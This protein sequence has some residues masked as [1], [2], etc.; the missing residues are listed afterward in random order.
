MSII[1]KNWRPWE[2]NKISIIEQILV[3][4]HPSLYNKKEKINLEEACTKL[5]ITKQ[6]FYNW[7]KANPELRNRWD[8]AIEIR[9]ESIKLVARE[10]VF[11][12]ITWNTKLRPKEKIEL[13]KWVLE[14][15]D[16]DFNPKQVIESKSM[17]LNF[18]VSIDEMENQLKNLFINQN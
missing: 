18:D 15:T 10:N 13:S 7:L 9:K 6:T 5:W 16:S 3:L 11:D 12:W 1:E 17:N 4:T 2:I 8:E 14:K